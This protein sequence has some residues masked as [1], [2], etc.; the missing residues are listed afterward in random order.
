MTCEKCKEENIKDKNYNE[1]LK[2]YCPLAIID[3]KECEA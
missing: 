3:C 2:R 1:H